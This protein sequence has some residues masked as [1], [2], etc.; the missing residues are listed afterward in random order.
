MGLFPDQEKNIQSIS[1]N[2][3]EGPRTGFVENT[4]AAWEATRHNDLFVSEGNNAREAYSNYITEIFQATGRKLSHPMRF[5]DFQAETVFDKQFEEF[6]T[7]VDELRLS[8][9]NFNIKTREDINAQIAAEGAALEADLQDVSG[10][11]TGVGALGVFTGAVGATI[12]DPAILLTLPFGAAAASGILRTAVV[13]G[14]VAVSTEAAIQPQ[15]QGYRDDLGLDA[16][17]DRALTN[18]L[19]AGVGGAGFGAGLKALGK[20]AGFSSK[21]LIQAFDDVVENPTAEQRGARMAMQ[22]V[23]AQAQ[24]NPFEDVGTARQE[25]DKRGAEGI[26]AAVDMKPPEMPER[27]VAA[28][29]QPTAL[30]KGDGSIKRF[31]P[32]DVV[33]D[34]K[35]FQFKAE[36]DEFGVTKRLKDVKKWDE[37]KAGVVVLWQDDGKFFVADGHQRIGLAKRLSSTDPDIKINA[38]VLRQADGV[39]DVDAR[40]IA[41]SKNIAE[42]T[43]S[44]LDAAKVLRGATGFELN[45]PPSSV[46]VRQAQNLSRVS[47]DAF[48]MIVNEIVPANYAAIVGRLVG[49]EKMH[50]AIMEVLAE[51]QPVNVVQAEAIVRQAQA[52]GVSREVQTSLFG[53]EEVTTSLFKDRARILDKTLKKLRNDKNV[54]RTLVQEENKITGVGTNRLDISE[55][56]RQETINGRAEELIQRLAHSHGQV[57]EALNDAARRARADGKDSGAVN[58]FADAVRSQSGR[59]DFL[60]G[61]VG[62]RGRAGQAAGE[63]GQAPSLDR[64]Q[65]ERVE[66]ADLKDF[67]DPDGVGPTAQE[68]IAM[69]EFVDGNDADDILLG[70][71]VTDTGETAPRLAK[72]G[73]LKEELLEDADF[74]KTIEACAS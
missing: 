8:G 15:I 13:E 52:A 63:G 51:A 41:A 1:R 16:G 33:I 55:N 45:L 2:F 40:I 27:A 20:L 37:I 66:P 36:G 39:T 49:D 29:Q 12:S 32:N 73:A 46:L 6:F 14:L 25:H 4:V 31:N 30:V 35:R 62:E 18:I 69:N 60:R 44:A 65:P 56:L 72:R 48:G 50:L 10:R 71:D 28:H 47:D 23:E 42:G 9:A 59:A 22:D 53:E 74:E 5:K 64:V 61:V 58:D 34:A 17:L 38:F 11:A 68:E 24:A 43:G 7:Q 54:F 3:S 26:K 57:S 67:S 70:F 19:F 21:K